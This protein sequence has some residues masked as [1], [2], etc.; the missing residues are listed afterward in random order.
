MDPVQAAF[1]GERDQTTQQRRRESLGCKQLL[2]SVQRKSII[3]IHFS[4]D[5][6]QYYNRASICLWVHAP[7]SLPK[8][9]NLLN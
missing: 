7:G 6:G 3:G 1:G 9:G 4:M 8:W 5:D 2:G